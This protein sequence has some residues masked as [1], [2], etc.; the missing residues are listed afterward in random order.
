MAGRKPSDERTP[1]NGHSRMEIYLSPELRKA[2]RLAAV[3]ADATI[4]ALVAEILRADSRIQ[5]EMKKIEE[6]G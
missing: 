1:R 2:T 3:K 4:S 6:G 5:K